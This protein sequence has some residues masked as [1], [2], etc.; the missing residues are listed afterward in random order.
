MVIVTRF[1][2]KSFKGK[3]KPTPDSTEKIVCFMFIRVMANMNITFK[4]TLNILQIDMLLCL[5]RHRSHPPND[6]DKFLHCI[7]FSVEEDGGNNEP[8]S[9]NYNLL[10]L[11]LIIV[12]TSCRIAK[13]FLLIHKTSKVVS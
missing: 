2:L 13:W 10:E 3:K 11:S 12:L 9:G 6:T 8:N 7:T 5:I 4:M 1:L